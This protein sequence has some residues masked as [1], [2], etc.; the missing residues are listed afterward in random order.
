MKIERTK[1]G[2]WTTRVFLTDAAGVK[3]S[4]R[5]THRDKA[6][7]RNMANDFLNEAVVYME[8]MI[9]SDSANRFLAHAE[10]ILSPNT[11]RG[12][13]CYFRYLEKHYKNFCMK[14][15][16]RITALDIQFLVDDMTVNGSSPKSVANRIGFI[17]TVMSH[18][19]RHIPKHSMPKMRPYEPN[20]PTEELIRKVTQ[21]AAGTRYEIPFALAVFGLRR[22]EICAVKA[23]DISDDNVLHVRRALAIDDDGFIYE[24]PPK[25]SASDRY[26]VL[27]PD[28]ADA[29]REKGRATTM[30]PTALSLGFPHLL[31]RAGIPESQRFRLHDCRHFFVSYC[32]D[33]LKLSDAQIIKLSGH[34]TDY[35]MKRV[36]RHA[37]TD[38]AAAVASSIAGSLLSASHSG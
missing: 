34:R 36:Y 13:K 31:K 27:P 3:H 14:S 23:E 8:S 10:K 29:I 1:S 22:G 25:E 35:V 4:K 17:S 12:Y 24:K 33:V 26:L 9:F 7:V 11:V 16:D 2:K 32:H 15:V 19:G 37:I 28:L 6:V 38:T 18:E 20:V 30:T 5:F 21:A